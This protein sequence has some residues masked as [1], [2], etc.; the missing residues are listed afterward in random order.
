M[1]IPTDDQLEA[2]YR[3]W[4]AQSYGVPPNRQAVAAAVAWGRQLV[5]GLAVAD[6][7][8]AEGATEGPP[9]WMPHAPGAFYPGRTGGA[10]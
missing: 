10:Q 6:R 2:N 3:D 1:N 8:G 5:D 7:G 9:D 4:W